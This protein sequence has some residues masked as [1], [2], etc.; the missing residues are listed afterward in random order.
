MEP[1]MPV[2]NWPSL[3][4]ITPLIVLM[5][6]LSRPAEATSTPA[7][8]E[9]RSETFQD[10]PFTVAW[11]DLEQV[12]LEL[13]WKDPEGVPFTNFAGLEAW[14]RDRGRA[15]VL[16]TNSGIY[17]EDRTPLG[18]HIEEGTT[19]RRLN[20]HK[21]GTSNFALK[22]NGVFYIDGT[23]AHIQTTEEYAAEERSPELAVQSGPQLVINGALHPQFKEASTSIHFRNGVGVASPHRVAIVISDL[24][25]NLYTFAAFFKERL[26]CDNAL[27]L[28]G[29]L[30]GLYAPALKRTAPGLEYV[31]MLAVTAPVAAGEQAHE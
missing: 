12:R 26:G 27:Y 21:G 4:I 7:G 11:I 19:R 20:P 25:V 22:P 18:L 15:L 23:G 24:P 31:G 16:A 13:F 2:G 14:L 9:F 10:V 3:L 17:A 5:S 29:A 28:D 6:A 1:E 8:V 30:S